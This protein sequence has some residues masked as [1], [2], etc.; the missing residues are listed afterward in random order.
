MMFNANK[1]LLT[2]IDNGGGGRVRYVVLKGLAV[3][4]E[5][6]CALAD[7]PA[8]GAVRAAFLARG[9]Y[10]D[11][12][13]AEVKSAKMLP[14][15][16]RRLVDGS[17]AFSEP[18][19][20]RFAAKNLGNGRQR[21]DLAAVSEADV[22]A[23]MRQLPLQSRA[24]ERVT[25][26][27]SAIAALVAQETPEPA[28]VLWLRGPN[29]LGLVV[30]NGA[31]LAKLLDRATSG[32]DA[33]DGRLERMR[34]SLQS[35]V[36]RTF[37]DRE[38]SL[39]LALGE[40]AGNAA[41]RG[42]PADAAS[43]ALETRLARRFT[44]S[45]PLA[46]LLWPE[47]YGLPTLANDYSLLDTGHQQRAWA[48]K[49]AFGLGA[50]LFAGGLATAAT[51]AAHYAE[52]QQLAA[53]HAS[54]RSKVEADYTALK[55]RLPTP[56]QLAALEQRL[57]I[58]SGA[59][60]FRV[61]SLLAWISEI[62]PNGA[63]IRK[64]E[65]SSAKPAAGAAAP[66]AQAEPHGLDILV[67]WELQGNYPGVEQLAASLTERLAERAKLTGSKLEYTTGE[68]GKSAAKLSTVLTPLHGM[69]SR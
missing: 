53:D 14:F 59:S 43:S 26:V 8:G 48:E 13:D 42:E 2:P 36:R 62:T 16:A 38:I 4:A 39:R 40:L 18:F 24:C 37:P 51:A 41:T 34:G 7:L 28:A 56:A 22:D 20:V 52:W 17:L 23:A 69:F 61:D 64:L 12:V 60:D 50:L 30:E 49:A 19:R 35:A 44:G 5:G 21:L 29:L 31:V 33:L 58:E 32:E 47:V 45:Q 6:E 68:Q 66:A 55:P 54:R 57:K 3:Q 67:V 10:F 25:L 15:Q 11:R 63:I 46:A 27:E 9:S 65:A 1:L